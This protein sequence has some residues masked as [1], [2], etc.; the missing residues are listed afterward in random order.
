[1]KTKFD[2]TSE[3][4]NPISTINFAYFTDLQTEQIF[5]KHNLKRYLNTKQQRLK[6]ENCSSRA[7][8]RE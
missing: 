6:H 3:K 1:M 4:I 8:L 5:L 2:S 7:N